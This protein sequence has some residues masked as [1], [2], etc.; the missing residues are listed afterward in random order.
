MDWKSLIPW[1]RRRE[2]R[3]EGEYEEDISFD[4]YL[5]K[6][7]NHGGNSYPFMNSWAPNGKTESAPNDYLGYINELYKSSGAVFACSVTRMM[8]FSEARFAFQQMES[9]RPGDMKLI[10]GKQLDIFRNRT[11]GEGGVFARA[12]QDVDLAGNHYMVRNDRP[13]GPPELKR[14]R[15][16]WVEIVLGDD[17]N[18]NPDAPVIAYIYK[19]GNT[20]DRKIW[21]V[22]P[23][24]GSNGAVAHWAPIPDPA[25][26][27]RGMSWMTP[28]IREIQ[29]DKSIND[30]KNR[31]FKGGA[32]PR[33]AIRYPEDLNPED[34]AEYRE[35]MES[36]YSGITSAYE[37]IY[38]GGGADVTV[39]GSDIRQ[40]DFEVVTKIGENRICAAARVPASLVGIGT[41]MEGSSLNAGNFDSAKDAF[42]SGTMRPL[43]RSFC[44]AYSALLDVPENSKLFVDDRDVMF[45]REDRTKV[46]QRQQLQATTISRYVMQG[47]TPESAVLAVQTDDLS[48]LEHTGLYSVQLLPPEISFADVS[49]KKKAEADA[50]A[51]KGKEGGG[52]TPSKA[53]NHPT[54]SKRKPVGRPPKDEAKSAMDDWLEATRYGEDWEDPT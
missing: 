40:L 6:F 46:A 12:I 20:Q 52:S 24:D 16:D 10:G 13:G 39:I 53:N 42:A 9:D 18:L 49:A 43:W 2:K 4:A 48:V 36:K 5:N 33:I 19:P 29:G 41:G 51:G 27:Y 54:G 15:P 37:N 1:R 7:F 35:L 34:A 21:E 47:Y 26:Q 30:H 14:L 32:S 8:I 25:A 22:Y 44:E 17:P 45:L 50:A 23:A 31:F 38:V 11:G 28:V 3:S